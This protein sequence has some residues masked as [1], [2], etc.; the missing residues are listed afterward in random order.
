VWARNLFQ[1][2]KTLKGTAG[3]FMFKTFKKHDKLL[4]HKKC[5]KTN[6]DCRSYSLGH[7]YKKN[8]EVFDHLKAPLNVPF[9]IPKNNETFSDF[10]GLLQ[11]TGKLGVELQ[12][13]YKY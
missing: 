5:E 1:N 10:S 12:E 9:Y 11:L 8:Y 2:P 3:P 7:M 4:Q 13:E 6:C